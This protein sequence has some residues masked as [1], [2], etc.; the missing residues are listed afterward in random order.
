MIFIELFVPRGTLDGDRRRRLA[1]ALG[2]VTRLAR[3]EDMQDGL[4]QAVGSLLQ[5]VVHEPEV[6]VVDQG[7][8]ADGAPRYVVRAHVP[9]PW[10]K[11]VAGAVVEYVTEAVAEV[12]DDPRRPY[13]EPVVQV[14]VVGVAEGSLG[15]LGRAVDSAA[16]VDLMN[17]P[18]REDYEQGRA[19]LDPVCGVYVVLDES[20]VTLER[21]GVLHGFCCAGCRDAFIEEEEKAAARA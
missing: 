17:E 3:G 8:A 4:R 13:R 19:L 11:A 9:G 20:A 21:D 15:V 16:I 18:R 10:R 1:E 6:W 12:E 2:D 14:Q 7:V 5:V